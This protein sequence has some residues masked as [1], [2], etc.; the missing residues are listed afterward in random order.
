MNVSL[1]YPVGVTH[2]EVGLSLNPKSGS[3]IE[4]ED[5]TPTC[6][7]QENEKVYY[8]SESFWESRVGLKQV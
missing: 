7:L 3:D 1:N 8:S 6:T 2:T 4:T 5:A